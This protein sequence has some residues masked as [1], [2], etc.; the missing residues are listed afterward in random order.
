[1]QIMTFAEWLK[2]DIIAELIMLH[3]D[4]IYI[5]FFMKLYQPCLMLYNI[6]KICLPSSGCKLHLLKSALD[7]LGKT[8]LSIHINHLQT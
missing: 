6:T 4:Y 7:V 5:V 8:F 3:A 1:M 2:Q